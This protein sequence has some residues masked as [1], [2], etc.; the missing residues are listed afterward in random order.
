[1]EI[2]SSPLTIETSRHLLRRLCFGCTLDEAQALVGRQAK[3]VVDEF[4]EAAFDSLTPED[5]WWTEVLP[6]PNGSTSNARRVFNQQNREWRDDIT[7]DWFKEMY[8]DRVSQRLTLFW[9]DHFVTSYDAYYYTAWGYRYKKLLRENAMGSFKRF[10]R[11]IGLD[12][13]MLRYLDGRSNTVYA[14]NENYARELL[15]LFTMGP[16][17][18][19]GTPNYSE[20][21]I[22][23]IARA[24]TGYITMVPQSWYARLYGPRHDKEDKT[25]FGQTGN[26]GYDDVVNI[27][28]EE[29]SEQIAHFISKKMLV[30]FVGQNPDAASV[31]ELS[32]V[33]LDSN[34]SLLHTFKALFSS[35]TFF[36]QAISGSRIKSPVE[37]FLGHYVEMGVPPNRD[38][39]TYLLTACSVMGQKLLAP[40]NVAGWPGH[41]NWI[42]TNTLTLRW[43][44]SD[45]IL[46]RE[47]SD[48]N[49]VE[50][51]RRHIQP[52]S[53]H[54]AVDVALSIAEHCFSIPMEWIEVPSID[55]PFE[56]DLH[57]LPLPSSLLDGPE[58]KINLVK[59]FLNGLPWYE[60]NLE[61]DGGRD[62]VSQYMRRLI[63]FPEYQ[64]M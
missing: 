63:Q 50:F 64:L 21:D 20:T 44:Y 46:R 52:G 3:D 51:A 32:R 55:E 56:G 2:H 27:L 61:T 19:D 38:Q 34:F 43:A 16:I 62:R 40:P 6:P 60:W 1:M 48:E 33:L 54:P 8:A 59:L 42:S 4:F 58:Y 28:F 25:F 13:A 45:A 26:F 29:R 10:V 24:L 35:K 36:Q 15:E 47:M 31:T 23:E 49:M 37:I 30:E 12:P 14:P 39:S 22:R 18:P 17:G 41:R 5:P 7:Y 57:E 53:T 9:H 11:A